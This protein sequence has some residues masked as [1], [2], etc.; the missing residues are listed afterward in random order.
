MAVVKD[1][2]EV[3]PLDSDATLI[4]PLITRRVGDSAEFKA[5]VLG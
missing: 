5:Q 4:D 3:R 2:Q 1:A